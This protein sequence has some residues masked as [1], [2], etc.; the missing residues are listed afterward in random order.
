MLNKNANNKL[1][2]KYLFDCIENLFPTKKIY[3]I[4]L[5]N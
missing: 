1:I 5:I 2:I 3:Y 4:K